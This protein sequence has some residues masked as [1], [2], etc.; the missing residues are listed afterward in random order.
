MI[1]LADRDPLKLDL[2]CGSTKRALDYVG[3]DLLPGP[4]VDV[5]GDALEVLRSLP[6]DRVTEIYTSHFLEH[7][8]D[9]TGLMSEVE[10]VLIPGGLLSA[11][12]PHFSNPYF[13][14]DPTHRRAFGLYTFSYYAADH[15]FRRRVPTYGHELR[16]RVERVELVFRSATEFHRRS[17]LRAVFGRLVNHNMWTQ[18]LYEE[19][20]PWI[21]P[22]YEIRV[23]LRKL[24]ESLPT[25][26]K[27]KSER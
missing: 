8:D 6:N 22:C 2:G 16:L 13:F 7:V 24:G 9:L 3:V 26:T 10:R 25:P 20:F 15:V 1:D 14:S 23:T 21:F 19:S 5:V 17:K 11:H 18:E 12:V 4:G 27:G